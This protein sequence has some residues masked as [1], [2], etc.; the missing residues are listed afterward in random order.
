MTIEL[1]KAL[2]FNTIRKHIKI[3]A[4]IWYHE[5]DKR[6]VIV[7]QD[8]VNGGGKYDSPTVVWPLITHMHANDHRYIKF[9]RTNK[10]GREQALNEYRQTIN[11]LYNSPC[12]AL[13]T[14]FNEGWGQ[15]DSKKI[16]REMQNLDKT[17]LFDP[18][19]GWHDQRAGDFKSQHV[20]FQKVKLSNREKRC[21]IVSEFGGLVLPIP[22]HIMEGDPVYKT[23]KTKEEWLTAFEE[24]I[25]RDVINNIPNGLAASIYTQLSD[26]EEEM[27]GFITFDREVVKVE[28][29]SIK[30]INDQVH[31]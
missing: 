18:T 27:N 17:R 1:V 20:Y 28:A 26:V 30:A 19:S 8:F 6:G 31:L 4:P 3:E 7:W 9:K 22:G 5:C 29:E 12:I 13:W 10:E 16:L 23:F 24:M 11:Y 2:G 14:I 15:F 25:K 21:Q